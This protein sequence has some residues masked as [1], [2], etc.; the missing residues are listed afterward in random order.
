MSN[1]GE[2]SK[3]VGSLLVLRALRHFP[4]DH[5]RAE[6]SFRSVVC[7]FDKRRGKKA[8][9][10]ALIILSAQ[11]VQ[12]ALVVVIFQH[13]IPEMVTHLLFQ[14][15]CLFRKCIRGQ[16]MPRSPKCHSFLEQ[17]LGNE[18]ELTRPPLLGLH[19][20]AAVP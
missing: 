20:N 11:T 9:Q 1:T 6:N 7:R 15:L 10:V 19:Y 13:A 5:R 4:C 17:L 14:F 8:H 2:S 3:G 16:T 18:A 12:Q